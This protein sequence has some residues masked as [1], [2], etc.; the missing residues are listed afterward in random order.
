MNSCRDHRRINTERVRQSFNECLRHGHAGVQELMQSLHPFAEVSITE[1]GN[2]VRRFHARA[3][4][5][6]GNEF[7]NRRHA[8]WPAEVTGGGTREVLQMVKASPVYPPN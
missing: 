8:S 7:A 1:G 5:G 4:Q 6:L 3:L 2:E